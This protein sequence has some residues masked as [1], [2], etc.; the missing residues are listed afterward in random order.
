MTCSAF[1]GLECSTL[2]LQPSP[3][4]VVTH[5]P[6]CVVG[7]KRLCNIC[8]VLAR[9][10]CNICVVFCSLRNGLQ[11]LPR[12]QQAKIFVGEN[13]LTYTEFIYSN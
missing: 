8:V 7:V 13:I 10:I 11:C 2:R 5:K 3:K 6:P 4:L 9:I 1:F 12:L